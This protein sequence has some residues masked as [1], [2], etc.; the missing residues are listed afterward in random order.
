MDFD[1][2]KPIWLQLVEEFS[3]RIASGSWAPGAKVGSV[4]EL[5]AEFGVNPNT[6]QRALTHLDESGLTTT[7][8]TVGRFVTSDPSHV[9]AMRSQAATRFVDD[10]VA[11]LRGLGL[12]YAEAATLLIDRWDHQQEES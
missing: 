5:A 11:A 12:T 1:E 2:D 3:R 6:V 4:R 8:R 9:D 10:L 7:E